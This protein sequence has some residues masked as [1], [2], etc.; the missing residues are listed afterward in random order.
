MKKLE[1]IIVNFEKYSGAEALDS[2]INFVGVGEII[3]YLKEYCSLMDCEWFL[4][5]DYAEIK[6]VDNHI[7][8]FKK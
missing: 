2:L 1:N 6:Y 3:H 4:D 5:T 7:I 8:I